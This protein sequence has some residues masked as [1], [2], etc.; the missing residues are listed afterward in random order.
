MA[1][2]LLAL[3]SNLGDRAA[4]LRQ[5]VGQL[6]R[7]PQ[8]VLMARSSWHETAPV[9]GP[10]GQ[11]LFLN[12]AALV[13]TSLSPVA[14]LAE[15]GRIEQ[16]LGRI[17][18]ERWEART[19]DLDVLLFDRVVHRG[20]DLTIP[21]P[22]MLDRAFVLEPAAEIAAWMTHP[23]T[24]WTIS[25]LLQQLRSGVDDWQRPTQLA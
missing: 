11:G 21:H 24:G 20:A 16:Q 8:T 23:E 2:C 5:A 25:R 12:G 19:I 4:S 3:G 15:I 6:A 17:R 18:A 7:L 10:P 9:G 1:H 22:R 13:S 14:L